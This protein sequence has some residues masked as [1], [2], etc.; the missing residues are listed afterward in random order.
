MGCIVWLGFGFPIDS[1]IKNTE[2]DAVYGMFVVG[3][4]AFYTIY[5]SNKAVGYILGVEVA[6]GNFF[7]EVMGCSYAKASK[8]DNGTMREAWQVVD[9][10]LDTL[11]KWCGWGRIMARDTVKS[12]HE[13]RADVLHNMYNFPK[14]ALNF[15]R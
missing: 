3:G 5:K 2:D 11:E 4:A 13:I 7:T 8:I 12:I 1:N 14:C 10:V 15:P 9:E 6:W